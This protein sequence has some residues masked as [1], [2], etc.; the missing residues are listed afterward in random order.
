LLVGN[1]PERN[2]LEQLAAE[3][4]MKEVIA[5][6]GEVDHGQINTYYKTIDLFVIPRIPDYAADWVTPLK[7]YEAMALER[8]IVVTDLPAL[9]EIVGENEERGLVAKPADVKSLATQIQ[10]Y[11]DDPAMR[12]SKARAAKEWVFAERTWSAN[13]KRYDAIYRRLMARSVSN[14]HKLLHA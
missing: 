1:G 10:R 2:N 13:A 6:P 8:P 3:L 14:D 12:Q 11:I 4:G 9:K 7:P 5:F